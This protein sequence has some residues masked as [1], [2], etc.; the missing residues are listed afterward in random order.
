[1]GPVADLFD[2]MDDLDGWFRGYAGSARERWRNRLLE[3]QGM[4]LESSRL[5]REDSRREAWN[6][7]LNRLRAQRRRWQREASGPVKT[8][9]RSL[10]V[11]SP[12]I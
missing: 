10:A 5:P 3:W 11:F 9:A 8:T 4:A 1:M 7:L 6:Q 12:E 2:A